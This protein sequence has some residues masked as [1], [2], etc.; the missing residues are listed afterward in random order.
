MNRR[1]FCKT[2]GMS[3]LA[4]SLM[5]SVSAFGQTSALTGKRP[6]LAERKFVSEAVEKQIAE[7]SRKIADADLRKMFEI[8]YPNTLD[9]TVFYE[10][11]NGKPDTYVITGDIDA[12][13]LRDSAAQ[14]FPFLSLIKSDEKLKKMIQGVI[15]RQTKFVLLDPYANAFYKD[16]NQKTMWQSDK[17]TPIPGVHERKWEVDSLCYVV[18]L[19]YAYYQ[20]TNDISLFDGNWKRAMKLIYE[21]FVTEQR[22]NGASPYFFIRR[23]DVMIDA[24]PHGGKGNPLKPVGLIASMFRPSDDA[25]TLPFLIPSN[26]FAVQSLRQLAEIFSARLGDKSFADNCLALANEVETAIRKYALAEHENFG[27]IYAYEVDG[28]GNKLFMDD[29]NVPSLMSMTYL[30][31][32]KSDDI[33]YRNTRRF[34]LS[35]NNPYFLRGKIAEGQSSPH[36]GRE[37]IW[38][39]GIIFRAMTSSDNAEIKQCLKILKTTTA[40]TGFMHESFHKDDDKKFTRSWFAWANTQ[41]GELI[42][43]IAAERPKILQEKF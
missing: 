24:P 5:P 33:V 3:I 43:K 10:E 7:V 13:W 39:L 15:N 12:M 26:F 35:E 41:F 16:P 37:N 34:L 30:G 40:N 18:R 38:H 6:A 4:A 42:V 36:T 25:T 17:P 2:S 9:T 31:A 32:V 28:F 29:A 8:C 19:A 21:T 11:I 23:T 1:E 27:K 14:V 22:K 20:Q